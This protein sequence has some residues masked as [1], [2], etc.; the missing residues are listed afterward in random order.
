MKDVR[1]GPPGDRVTV[2][3]QLSVSVDTAFRAFTE[4]IDQW[5]RLGLPYRVSG[6]RRGVLRFEPGVGGRLYE[7]IETDSG[8]EIAE[9]GRVTAWEP[10]RRLAFE[11]R[12]V[13]FEPGDRTIVEVSFEPRGRGTLV[14]VRHSGW[15][16][17]RAD[18]PARHGQPVP[19]FIRGMGLWWG[20]LM[21]ALRE[22][23]AAENGR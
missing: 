19:E 14:T 17:I 23:L 10:P 12:A 8:S 7:T 11:W 21:T 5:W 6:N 13:N 16:A 2:S 22:Y 18:H 20:D 15:S 4:E 9:S 3:V 1:T